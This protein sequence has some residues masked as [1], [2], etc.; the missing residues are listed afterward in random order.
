MVLEVETGRGITV[1]HTRMYMCVCMCAHICLCICTQT[2]MC[3]YV[4]KVI[5]EQG[6]N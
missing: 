4:Y 3:V 6:S 2:Y 1:I 5:H